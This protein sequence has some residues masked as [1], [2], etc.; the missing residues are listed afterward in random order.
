MNHIM[1]NIKVKFYEKDY[2]E[3]LWNILWEKILFSGV[4]QAK[5]YEKYYERML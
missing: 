1:K 3:I 2:G 4:G 5:Y